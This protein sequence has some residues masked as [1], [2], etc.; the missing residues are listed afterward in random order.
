MSSDA[1]ASDRRVLGFLIRSVVSA[2]MMVQDE[3]P[4]GGAPGLHGRLNDKLAARDDE[5][6]TRQAGLAHEGWMCSVSH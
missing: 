3:P 5:G 6:A 2:V 1:F 4:A